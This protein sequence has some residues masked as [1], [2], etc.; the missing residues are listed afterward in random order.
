MMMLKKAC[1]KK[2][3]TQE[4]R[5]EIYVF[6]EQKL[7]YREMWRRLWRS[8]STISKEIKRNSIW[9][10]NTRWTIYEP[11]KAEQERLERRHKENHNHIILRKDFEQREL[12]EKWLKLK[13]KER[14]P[15]EILWRIKLDLWRDV[16][17]VATLYRFIR[18]GRP[19]LQRH[20][21]GLLGEAPS[22]HLEP[23][24]WRFGPTALSVERAPTGRHPNWKESG[25]PPGC[26][27]F[28]LVHHRVFVGGNACPAACCCCGFSRFAKGL[29]LVG[30]AVFLR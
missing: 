3:L 13:G 10:K 27:D 16:V 12:I 17:S 28:L 1:R 2:H 23:A 20:Y 30:L 5:V 21:A 29:L 6:L 14:W 9:C 19:V 22:G 18:E 24:L 11:I 4:E 7:S 25:S 15:D 26:P 8:H